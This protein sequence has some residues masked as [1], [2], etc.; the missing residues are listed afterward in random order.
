MVKVF[1]GVTVYYEDYRDTD[2]SADFVITEVV[3]ESGA[4]VSTFP[5]SVKEAVFNEY[6]ELLLKGE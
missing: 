5:H 2:V 6:K 3:F 4:L 1:N